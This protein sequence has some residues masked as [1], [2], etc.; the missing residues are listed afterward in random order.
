MSSS[1]HLNLFN[2][3]QPTLSTRIRPSNVE[4]EG[5]G[6]GEKGGMKGRKKGGKKEERKKGG[7]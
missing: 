7:R 1:L 3:V 4:R 6:K 5:V 2:T